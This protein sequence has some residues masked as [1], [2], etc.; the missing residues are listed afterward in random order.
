MRWSVQKTKFEKAQKTNKN[1]KQKQCEDFLRKESLLSM[2]SYVVLLNIR[3]LYQYTSPF[4][5]SF[6]KNHTFFT[7]DL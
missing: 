4:L 6:Q 2:A 3:H 5:P 7:Y 1:K